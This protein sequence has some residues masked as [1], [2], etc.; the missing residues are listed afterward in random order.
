MSHGISITFLLI[1]TQTLINSFFIFLRETRNLQ[2]M[3]ALRLACCFFSASTFLNDE[4]MN[5]WLRVKFEIWIFKRCLP[6]YQSK[7]GNVVLRDSQWY[8]IAVL[9][10]WMNLQVCNGHKVS[11]TKSVY[12]LISPFH[13]KPLTGVQK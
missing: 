3:L 9:L 2:G 7:S 10:V 12:I 1:I 5:S 8:G 6:P 13:F 11:N 4:I